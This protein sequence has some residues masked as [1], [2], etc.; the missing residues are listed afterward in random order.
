MTDVETLKKLDS[1]DIRTVIEILIAELGGRAMNGYE[2]EPMENSHQRAK[3]HLIAA[4]DELGEAFETG[5][6]K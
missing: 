5:A 3:E 1:G 2:D 6:I 4:M